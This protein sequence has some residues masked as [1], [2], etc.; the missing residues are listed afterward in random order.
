MF[1]LD[2]SDASIEALGLRKSFG[3]IKLIGYG[4]VELPPD[5][6]RD[7]TVLK[8]RELAEAIR[9]L[10]KS[11]K[12]EAIKSRRVILSLP[13]SR[14]FTHIF[15][16]PSNL[17]AK[18]IAEVLKFEAPNALPISLEEVYSDFSFLEKTGN[19]REIFFVAVPKKVVD[20][21]CEAVRSAGLSPIIFDMESANFARAV[22]GA[23]EGG[24]LIVDIGSRTTIISIFDKRALRFTTNIPVAGNLFT[25][26]IAKKLK[27]QWER[28]EEL[29]KTC[30]LIPKDGKC[31]AGQVFLII[32]S[33]LQPII[34]EIQSTAKFYEEKSGRKIK[35]IILCGGSSMM[36][37]IVDYFKENFGLEVAVGKPFAIRGLEM[38]KAEITPLL[39]NV[40]G[41]ALRGTEKKPERVGI[42]LMFD[43]GE[44]A[45]FKNGGLFKKK[46][47]LGVAILGLVSLL[48]GLSYF[49]F[50]NPQ[51][52]PLF[53][54]YSL[55][56][57]VPVEL[58]VEMSTLGGLNA[59]YGR[60][61]EA[62]RSGD[63]VFPA[64]G[65]RVI[66]GRAVGKVKIFNR[67][68]GGQTLIA[69]TRLLSE[70]NGLFRLKDKITV[71]AGKIGEAEV[72]A[73]KVGADGDIGP[74]EFTIPGLLQSL[75]KL[76]YA[77][78]EAPMTGGA[79]ETA[80]VSAGD[81]EQAKNKLVEKLAA[82]EK[83][84]VEANLGIGEILLPTALSSEILQMIADPGQDEAA[85]E[86]KLQMTTKIKFLI[87]S[88]SAME[89]A[90]RAELKKRGLRKT[91]IYG[92]KNLECS[93]TGFDGASG[94]A[95]I[96]ISAEAAR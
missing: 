68:G 15:K 66:E 17:N 45:K 60:V 53:G 36:P 24:S 43:L 58:S 6:V 77:V 31:R 4:R 26:I 96:K 37:N 1:G 73:D 32:Q 76:I 61:Q 2:I 25:E 22:G 71:Q 65:E 93:L 83:T 91:E 39:L 51:K 28:A 3:R 81:I 56:K 85:A 95:V 47:L 8:K 63:K 54:Q 79:V 55:P 34:R 59:N 10:L 19:E 57:S 9:K 88:R 87:V 44:T 48:G 7:G 40:F 86:F 46:I 89:G 41:L 11:A 74:S 52:L 80:V 50:L 33:A 64:T 38:S 70:G 75:Q 5:V 84:K 27:I 67:S 78:S 72:Y 14:V 82:E 94:K 30:G 20:D 90:M 21:F 69:T 29:K 12:P 18:Q 42:N 92:F 23:A 49:F 35:K 62:E 16:F 13:E